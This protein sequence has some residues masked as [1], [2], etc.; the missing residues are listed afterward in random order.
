MLKK[1]T[2]VNHFFVVEQFYTHMNIFLAFDELLGRRISI[3]CSPTCIKY[4]FSSLNNILIAGCT[5]LLDKLSLLELVKNTKS[6]KAN[7]LF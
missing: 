1:R 3:K 2:V 4:F 7:R 6:Y 5:Y